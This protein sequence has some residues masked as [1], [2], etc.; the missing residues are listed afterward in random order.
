MVR[1]WD[2]LLGHVLAEQ[3]MERD[4]GAHLG[5]SFPLSLCGCQVYGMTRSA[6]RVHHL[7]S[8]MG[9]ELRVISQSV[10]PSVVGCDF[11][12]TPRGVLKWNVG[13]GNF[14]QQYFGTCK[15]NCY[16]KPNAQ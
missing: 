12:W 7:S 1:S 15:P 16:S 14:W 11:T 13:L 6:H 2:V 8:V 10:T 4:A 5:F 9:S 3:E